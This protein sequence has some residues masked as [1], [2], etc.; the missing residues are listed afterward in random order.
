MRIGT[1][2]M[3]CKLI[4]ILNKKEI[5]IANNHLYHN[6]LYEKVKL[7]ETLVCLKQF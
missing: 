5:F 4:D 2:I 6:P 3:I 1:G 7:F